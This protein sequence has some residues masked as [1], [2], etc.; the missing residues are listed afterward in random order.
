[1]IQKR[2]DTITELSKLRKER[3]IVDVE[4]V[5]KKIKLIEYTLNNL[6]CIPYVE[7]K[8]P[9]NSEEEP[10]YESLCWRSGH[11]EFEGAPLRGCSL[12]I[13]LKMEGYLEALL[14]KIIRSFV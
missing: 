9:C 14:D 3:K 4:V 7:L 2:L 8:I 10:S 11:I 12:L 1:M 13:R 5:N 6:E